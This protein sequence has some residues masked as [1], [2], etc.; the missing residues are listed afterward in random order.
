MNFHCQTVG[1]EQFPMAPTLKA[2]R[3]SPA[4]RNENVQVLLL[5]QELGLRRWQLG[6]TQPCPTVP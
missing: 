1:L 6:E 3:V 5:P 2:G 4:L